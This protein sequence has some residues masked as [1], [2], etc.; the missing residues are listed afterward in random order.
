MTDMRTANWQVYIFPSADLEWEL[1]EWVKPAPWQCELILAVY[2][3]DAWNIQR[4]NL[5]FVDMALLHHPSGAF[6]SKWDETA[7][8]LVHR[9]D[10]RCTCSH[11]RANDGERDALDAH[12]IFERSYCL[13]VMNIFVFGLIL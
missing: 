11:S 3:I 13:A 5:F 9:F 6:K 1:S 10:M 12:Q 4:L 8:Q 7:L 2:V